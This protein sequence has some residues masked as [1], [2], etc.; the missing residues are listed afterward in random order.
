MRAVDIA[1]PNFSWTQF[2]EYIPGLADGDRK[3]LRQVLRFGGTALHAALQELGMTDQSADTMLARSAEAIWARIFAD[4]NPQLS[5]QETERVPAASFEL[6]LDR[7]YLIALS[8]VANP[9]K[10]RAL[11]EE[12]GSVE[13]QAVAAD[14]LAAMKLLGLEQA[15]FSRL[16]AQ[17][18]EEALQQLPERDQNKVAT[19]IVVAAMLGIIEPV[20]G[21]TTPETAG[22]ID[23]E[24]SV[25]LPS[26]ADDPTSIPA[27]PWWERQDVVSAYEMLGGT[28]NDSRRELTTLYQKAL[29]QL[30]DAGLPSRDAQRY[31]RLLVTAFA[32]ATQ[33]DVTSLYMQIQREGLRGV[34]AVAELQSR[35]GSTLVSQALE[36]ARRGDFGGA[37]P[38]LLRARETTPGNA[39]SAALLGVLTL[40]GHPAI[41]FDP[42]KGLEY[43]QTATDLDSQRPIFKYWEGVVLEWLQQPQNAR[44]AYTACLTLD[45]EHPAARQRLDQ[46]AV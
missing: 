1:H 19:V 4:A 27:A 46:L 29:R 24:I 18:V 12:L 43:I 8:K 44:T 15:T 32:V 16:T 14:K 2:V 17:S 22:E 41:E 39:D 20:A 45:P 3:N 28:P 21:A 37:Y 23:G 10:I 40:S 42:V 34:R 31:R 9:K 7:L 38:L 11:A 25:S 35:L 5:W 33:D 6:G 30:D 36:L 13:L 26:T